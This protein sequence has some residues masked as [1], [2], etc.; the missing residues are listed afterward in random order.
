MQIAVEDARAVRHCR[1]SGNA[2]RRSYGWKRWG[3]PF[4]A[5]A[6]V[7][8]V[9]VIVCCQSAVISVPSLWWCYRRL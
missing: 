6:P 2:L 1:S 5:A 4:A 8:V 3:L 9:S 7:G